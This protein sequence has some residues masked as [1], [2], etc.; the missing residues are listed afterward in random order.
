L[1]GKKP[2]WILI[3][4]ISCLCLQI[5]PMIFHMFYAK[6]CKISAWLLYRNVSK[7]T[8]LKFLLQQDVQNQKLLYY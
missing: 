6:V 2:L 5:W 7:I 1:G 3:P 8:I 4:D